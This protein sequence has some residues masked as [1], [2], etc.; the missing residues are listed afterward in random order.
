MVA[1]S[2]PPNR[3]RLARLIALAADF[4]QVIAFPLFSGGALSPLNNVLDLGIA[5]VMIALVGWHWAFLPT[6]LAEGLPVLDLFPTWTAAVYW[7]TRGQGT[8]STIEPDI[9]DR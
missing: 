6:F 3:V 7:V 1:S 5:V 4:V 9:R 8:I 2:I